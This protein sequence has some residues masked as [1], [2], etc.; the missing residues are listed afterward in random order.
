[1]RVL[2]ACE[3]SGIVSGAFRAAG[4]EAWS[5]DLL[6]TEGDARWHIQ[7][8][9]L[10]AARSRSWDLMV[11]HPPCTMLCR[12]GA[13]WWKEPGRLGLQEEALA[14]VRALMDAPIPRIAIENPPGAI[15]TRIR[16]A[17]QSVHPWWF[18]DEMS[19]HTC[20]W[21]KGLPRLRPTKVVGR[22][23]HITMRS[24]KRMPAWY[25]IG[26]S[27]TRGLERSRTP[28]GLASA[29]AEQWGRPSGTSAFWEA[30]QSA[31]RFG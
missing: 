27:P 16:P 12:A 28:V 26:P 30:R 25:A 7:G 2:V 21:L 11:A 13:R 10:A 14:F 15:G 24:G 17:D 4:H 6:P 18:G 23:A 3:Y 19:K 20:L 9:A 1:M 22:G 29:M 31:L 5:C 8:D